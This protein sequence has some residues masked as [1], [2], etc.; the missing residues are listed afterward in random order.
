MIIFNIA[1]KFINIFCNKSKNYSYNCRMKRLSVFRT[2]SI[3]SI[4]W[5]SS[6]MTAHISPY[7]VEVKSY[8]LDLLYENVWGSIYHAE[9]SQCDSTPT[10]T[11]T[12]HR[13]NPYRASEQRWIAISQEMLNN[14]YRASLVKNPKS[15]LFK[16]KIE[17]GDTVWIESPHNNNINGWWI[18]RDAKNAKLRKSIDFLQTVGDNTLYNNDPQWSGKFNDISIYKL[19]NSSYN[20]FVKN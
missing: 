8:E 4:F 2:M 3:F 6:G 10:Q 1:R 14:S 9:I 11:A 5:L 18:V 15:Q 7:P 20:K 12:G 13:I 16:G 19:K 17:Y